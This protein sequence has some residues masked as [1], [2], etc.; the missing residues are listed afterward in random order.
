MGEVGGWLFKKNKQYQIGLGPSAA[1][2]QKTPQVSNEF[3]GVQ[4]YRA[5]NKLPAASLH[6]CGL[7]GTKWPWKKPCP[8]QRWRKK[9]EPARPRDMLGSGH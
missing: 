7:E 5:S 2:P 3:P 4:F 6:W 9:E 8:H 1:Y